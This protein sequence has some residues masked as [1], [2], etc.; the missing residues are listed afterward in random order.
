M[1]TYAALTAAASLLGITGLVHAGQ[2][3]SPPVP[4]S[5]SYS[6][7]CY[8]RNV[9]AAPIAVNVQIVN[10]AGAALT[11]NFDN[12]NTGSLAPGLSCAV[13][14]A[15]AALV[16]YAACS[17][18]TSGSVKKLRGS[19]EVRYFVSPNVFTGGAADLQ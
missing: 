7:I 12:C 5:N 11:T 3:A 4:S 10:T 1:K 2:I 13:Q 19:F 16:L 9:G 15:D 18:T 17:A 14:T 8:V 6:A